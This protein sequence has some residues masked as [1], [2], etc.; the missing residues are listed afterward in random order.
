MHDAG[1]MTIGHAEGIGGKH[2][3]KEGQHDEQVGIGE[4]IDEAGDR[5]I[6]SHVWQHLFFTHPSNSFLIAC[7]LYPYRVDSIC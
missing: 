4:R 7:H 2:H 1:I 6:G 3:H 5:I